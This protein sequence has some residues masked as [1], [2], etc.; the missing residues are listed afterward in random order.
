MV[1]PIMYLAIGFLVAL[2]LGLMVMPL[3]HNRA[4]RLTKKRLEASTPV[5]LAEIQAERDHLRAG[6]AMSARRLE[7]DVEKL[8]NNAAHQMAEIGR[9]SDT[10]NRLKLDLEE[11]TSAIKALE[12][13][14]AGFTERLAA[15]ENELATK[16]ELLRSTEAALRDKESELSRLASPP[17]KN[18]TVQAPS[19]VDRVTAQIASLK[20]QLGDAENDVM[21]TQQR[22]AQQR[23]ASAAAAEELAKIRARAEELE[24]KIA[25][26][27]A[28]LTSREQENGE[29]RQ[30]LETAEKSGHELR[31]QLESLRGSNTGVIE[32][33]EP[34]AALMAQLRQIEDE[35]DDLK[36]RLAALDQQAD[37]IRRTEQAENALLRER[38]NSIAAEV[39][40]LAITL[41]GPQSSIEAILASDKAQAKPKSAAKATTAKSGGAKAAIAKTATSKTSTVKTAK[42]KGDAPAADLSGGSLAE[43]IRALQAQIPRA[44]E[45]S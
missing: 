35:R 22:L 26:Q 37:E 43:R 33:A 29:L 40:R 28:L 34:D 12:D 31:S 6:F 2:L 1:E 19:E 24:R 14:V 42:P 36:T 30:R 45:S 16:S 20:S 21:A 7:Q 9:K 23:D 38:I 25:A 13:S 8:R 27:T 5:S 10:I 4:V 3:V 39:A 15:A 11:K 17:A 18:Q 41:E 44:T 32:Q